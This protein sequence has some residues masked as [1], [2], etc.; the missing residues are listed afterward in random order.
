MAAVRIYEVDAT[1][2]RRFL[3]FC[4][5]TDRRNFCDFCYGNALYSTM[6]NNNISVALILRLG[7]HLT[8]YI[9]ATTNEPLELAMLYVW[10]YII[11][12]HIKF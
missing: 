3:T 10:R 2:E 9:I 5:I 4:V 11:N 7:L 12:I 1:L 6:C 8:L